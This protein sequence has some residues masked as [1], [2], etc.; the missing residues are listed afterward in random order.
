MPSSLRYANPD[1]Y[2]IPKA[3]WP[4]RRPDICQHIR[5]PENGAVR[6]EERGRELTELLPRVNRL[7]ARNGKVGEVRMEQGRVVVPPLEAE[8]RPESV[9]R[10]EETVASRL[11]LIDLPDLL[12][13]VD[14][15]TGFSQDLRHLSG[16]EPRRSDFL[17]PLYAALLS[18]GCN[19]GFARMAQM[20]DISADRLA[21][22][23]AWP[24]RE[25]TLQDAPTTLV[26][27][28]HGLP[29]TQHWGGGTLSSSDGQRVSRWPARFAMPLPYRT[30]F[31]IRV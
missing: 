22:C 17:P 31:A 29:L 28:H 18:H 25:D 2:L 11:P 30:T 16:H 3:S 24:L 1:T 12:I 6:L 8:E 19:F 21:W 10:L 27:F 4:A 13:A 15:W 20:A 7:I 14:Q 26:N 9:I 23:T 5:A